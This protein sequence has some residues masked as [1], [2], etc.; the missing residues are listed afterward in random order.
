MKLA[1]AYGCVLA[2]NIRGIVD[3]PPF[4]QSAMDGYAFRFSDLSSGANFTVTGESAA[5]KN[6]T[7]KIKPGQVVRIFTGAAVPDGADTVVMQE[8]ISSR[9]QQVTILDDQIRKGA[10]VRLRGSHFMKGNVA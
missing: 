1:Q 6:Y 2:G 9:N 10:N 8:K 5:G 7:G 3:T 4:H